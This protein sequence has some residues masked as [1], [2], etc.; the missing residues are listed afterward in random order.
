MNTNPPGLPMLLT[1]K[2]A[3]QRLQCSPATVYQLCAAKLLPHS[4]VGLGRGVI[5]IAEADI[6]RY[7]ST[8]HVEEQR[9]PLRF[10]R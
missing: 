9:L 2:Q 1:V 6:A 4:R 3:A 7:L 5:R 10:I 8:K